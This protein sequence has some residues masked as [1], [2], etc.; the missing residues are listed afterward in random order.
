MSRPLHVYFLPSEFEPEDLRD[1]TAVIVDILRASTTMTHA[2]AN[3]ADCVIP[4]GSVDD[5]I[6]LRD[7]ETGGS[8]LLGG[9]RGGIKID[10]FDL[11]NSPDDYSQQV[12]EKRKIGFTTTNGTRAL[13]RS[14]QATEIIIGAFVN[15]QTVAS[16]LLK[17]E[18]AVHI[19]CAGTDGAITGE[20]VLFAGALS[21]LLVERK[22]DDFDVTDSARIAM[23]F[24]HQ[25][26]GSTTGSTEVE[27][28]MRKTQGGRNLIRLGYEKDI[29]TASAID[30]VPVLGK[31][32]DGPVIR[33]AN[34]SSSP[35]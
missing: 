6:G 19:V 33:S 13:L 1:G 12:V 28:A 18:N 16:H 2:L 5:A 24:W 11:S 14:Q 7:L 27:Q 15:L 8:Y 4:C 31:V 25:K 10:G 29:A 35:L 26:C 17:N 30:S 32:F 9:E 20:D 34:G 23:S 21:A 22:A 3:G